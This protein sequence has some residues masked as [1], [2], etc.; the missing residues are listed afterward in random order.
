MEK[1]PSA[2]TFKRLIDECVEKAYE[3]IAAEKGLDP[4]KIYKEPYCERVSEI[5]ASELSKRGIEAEVLQYKGWD[6]VEHDF[7][8][9]DTGTGD[10]IVDPTWQQFLENPEPSLPKALISRVSE[11]A[12]ALSAGGI[13]ETKQHI[14][15][16]KL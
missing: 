5:L 11:L 8:R 4:E 6:I 7:V 2:E 1:L 14:W 3:D 13:P 15:L 9:A 12:A 16:S 10:W